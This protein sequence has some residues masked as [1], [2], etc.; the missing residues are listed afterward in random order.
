MAVEA[1]FL[2]F[3]SEICYFKKCWSCYISTWFISK[4]NGGEDL[5]IYLFVDNHVFAKENDVYADL[6]QMYSLNDTFS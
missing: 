6:T 3:F 1:F 4:W 2:P 5:R